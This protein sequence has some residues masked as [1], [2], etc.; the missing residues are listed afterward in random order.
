MRN[1]LTMMMFAAIMGTIAVVSS[2]ASAADGWTYDEFDGW[3]VRA[4][5][6]FGMCTAVTNHTAKEGYMMLPFAPTGLGIS[7][8][9]SDWNIPKG[10]YPIKIKVDGRTLVNN[11]AEAEEATITM[12]IGWEKEVAERL[13]NGHTL[14][15]EAGNVTRN[16]SLDGSYAAML[17]G[18][19]CYDTL[20]SETESENPFDSDDHNPFE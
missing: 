4:Y 19:E 5:D 13:M 6:E 12:L 3:T 7:F 17:S 14:T 2:P 15:L 9:D 11:V 16:F 20:Y 1:I 10:R 8:G 18:M